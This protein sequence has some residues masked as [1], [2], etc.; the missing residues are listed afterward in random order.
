M[1]CTLQRCGETKVFLPF[2]KWVWKTRRNHDPFTQN[3]PQAFLW[4]VSC[5]DFFPHYWR[6]TYWLRRALS[7]FTSVTCAQRSCSKRRKKPQNKVPQT[8]KRKIKIVSVQKKKVKLLRPGLTTLQG[9]FRHTT[10]LI[11]VFPYLSWYFLLL[12]AL[13]E[14]IMACSSPTISDSSSG[15]TEKLPSASLCYKHLW[16]Q[17]ND[18]QHGLEHVQIGKTKRKHV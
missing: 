8:P 13:K 17:I 16:R 5:R 1:L 4:A 7:T 18:L 2:L 15:V 6:S 9:Q 3:N 11:Y 14:I 12:C 10:V